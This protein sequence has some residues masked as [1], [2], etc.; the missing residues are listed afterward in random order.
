MYLKKIIQRKEARL[1]GQENAVNIDERIGLAN[2]SSV[3]V[4]EIDDS[5]HTLVT[6]KMLVQI[7]MKVVLD[8]LTIFSL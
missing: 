2:K 1:E 8:L 6:E 5:C 7:N 3:M 4:T